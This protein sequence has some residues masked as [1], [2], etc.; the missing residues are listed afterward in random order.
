MLTYALDFFNRFPRKDD[1]RMQVLI[2]TVNKGTSDKTADQI[3]ATMEAAYRVMYGD[4]GMLEFLTEEEPLPSNIFG[5]MFQMNHLHVT[6]SSRVLH[7]LSK[8]P[9]KVVEN[10]WN[11]RKAWI[12]G[13]DRQVVMAY[14]EQADKDLVDFL[15]RR[16]YELKI[17]GSLFMLI[18]GR[19]SGSESQLGDDNDMNRKH[20]LNIYMDKA[21][22][23]LVDTKRV[24]AEERDSFNIPI[25]FRTQEEVKAAIDRC[26][27]FKMENMVNLKIADQMNP[28]PTRI[29]T[30]ALYG[31]DRA[32]MAREAIGGFI[33]KYFG[34]DKIF[35]TD[36]TD[37]LFDHYANIAGDDTELINKACFTQV[38]AVS[39][40]RV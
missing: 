34:E 12:Q 8:V 30:P 27:G 7:M 28:T 13:S 40:T 10:G 2:A 31:I 6:V 14:A 15:E 23:K 36:N 24:T 9:E 21:W 39:V 33:E 35:Q 26:G 38:I 20:P 22:Q 3:K 16:K 29:Y 25:Y 19:P 1:S 37:T 18:D 32:W 4:K 5:R 11:N 17:G